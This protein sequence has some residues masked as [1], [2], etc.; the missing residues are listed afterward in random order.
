M[1]RRVSNAAD[2]CRYIGGECGPLPC[3]AGARE[4]SHTDIQL[5]HDCEDAARVRHGG[6][7][8]PS[9]VPGAGRFVGLWLARVRMAEAEKSAQWHES[10]GDGSDDDQNSVAVVQQGAA[11]RF[12]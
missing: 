7:P 3:T 8:A 6:K 5:R 2:V 9:T 1:T 11:A 4:T 10:G 12:H